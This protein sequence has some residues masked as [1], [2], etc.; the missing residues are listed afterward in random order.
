VNI[1]V[2]SFQDNTDTIGAKYIHSYLKSH[3]HKSRLIL[4]CDPDNASDAS[5]LKFIA[6]ND[7][8][9]VGISLMSSEFYRACQFAK[10]FKSRF[11]TIPLVFG[12]IH[13]TIAP[14]ECL[15]VADI[16]VRGEGEHTFLELVRC[17]EEGR[18]YSAL[19]GICL[20]ADGQIRSNPP[21]A[22]EMDIDKFPFPKHLP[23][24]M[25][26]VRRKKVLPMNEALFAS[27]SRYAGRFPN[28]ITTRGCPFSCSYCCNSALK[29]YYGRY[30][31]RRRSVGSVISE[32]LE[33]VSEHNNCFSLNIQDD[34][35][36]SY[37]ND[38]ISEFARQ[39]RSKVRLP[40]VIR[41]TPQYIRKE[42]LA[43]FKE[44]GLTMIMVGLQSGSDRVNREVF[45]RD[46]TSDVFLNAARIVKAAGL[47]AYYDIILDNPYEKEEDVLKTL[48]VILQIPRPFQFQLFSLCLYRGTELY[49]RAIL[50]GV[51][52]VDP[53]VD[54]YGQLTP[55]ILNKLI[56]MAPT[57]PG[58]I[59]EYFI[60][61]RNHRLA[62]GAINM[63]TLF[64]AAILKPV[65]FIRLIHRSYGSKPSTTFRL[66]RY[67][68]RT[69]LRKMIKKRE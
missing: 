3:G 40:F 56:V 69:A 35:F 66:I 28:V 13:A 29:E 42:N 43:L 57:V 50:D 17:L 27:V 2:I 12:G 24:D 26:I 38:W 15:S 11:K 41:T 36:L 67:F 39:Y 58:P 52:F 63:F 46:I 45:K 49:K 21:R 19:P 10:D 9:I 64:N 23:K 30:P 44:S 60:R 8:R 1:A 14:E 18:D 31:V 22:L 33:I 59:I 7:I 25:Y 5:I 16:A 62:A 68:Y 61:H 4:Q 32:I 51:S 55:A 53:R 6:D 37:D 48:E 47:A 20:K 34:C 65:S 54:N